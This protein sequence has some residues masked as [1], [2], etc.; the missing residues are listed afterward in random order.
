[1]DA[2]LRVPRALRALLLDLRRTP[3]PGLLLQLWIRQEQKNE[4]EGVGLFR[5]RR[6]TQPKIRWAV[7]FAEVKE[8]AM[9]AW[10]GDT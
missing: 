5:K 10:P 3:T 6:D 2:L 8:E 4:R 1:M 9:L 7:R